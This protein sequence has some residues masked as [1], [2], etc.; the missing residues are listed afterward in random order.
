VF[1]SAHRCAIEALLAPALGVLFC[2]ACQAAAEERAA[3][4]AHGVQSIVITGAKPVPPTD[5]QLTQQ[6][7]TALE[8]SPYL[9]ASR[10]TVT[11]RNGVVTLDGLVGDSWDLR[12]AIRTAGR[13]A[14]I[15]QL[16]ENLDVVEPDGGP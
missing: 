7:E 12:I 9:D 6:V 13:V 15:R 14:G 1:P 10:V 2:W 4:A 11:T 3:P 8:A 16:I 5:E